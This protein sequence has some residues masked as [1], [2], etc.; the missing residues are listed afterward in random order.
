MHMP[1]CLSVVSKETPRPSNR[2]D[3][4]GVHVYSLVETLPV[5][6]LKDI[7]AK[8]ASSGIQFLGAEGL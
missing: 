7:L 3:D 1:S 2:T 6:A 5:V 8:A 4:T